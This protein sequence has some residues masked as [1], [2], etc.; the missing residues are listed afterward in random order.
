MV[1][2]IKTPKS[3]LR[4]LNY[5]ENKVK[6]G[7]ARLIHA[8]NF[9]QEK[10]DMNFYDKLDRFQHLNALNQRTTNKT[11]HI[12]L[13][14]HP[15]ETFSPEKLASIADDYM[16]RI[17]F[18]KQPYLVYEHFDAGHPHIHIV[19]SCIQANGRRIPLHNIGR[20]KSEPARKAIESRYGLVRAEDQQ[21]QHQ[22]ILPVNAQKVIYGQVETKR[23]ITN[24]LDAVLKTYKYSSLPE[25]NAILRLYNVAADRGK[26]DSRVFQKGGLL[27]RVLD[28]QGNKVGVPIKASSIHSKPTLAYLENQFQKNQP[29]KEGH[30]GRLKTAI[31][32]ALAGKKQLSLPQLIAAL[33]KQ[34]IATVRRQS[35]AGQLYGI[36]FIDHRTRCVFNGS[37]LGKQ[38]SAVGLQKRCASPDQEGQRPS[39]AAQQ[40]QN[41]TPEKAASAKTGQ[42]PD[43]SLHKMDT[44]LIPDKSPAGVA[45]NLI[46]QLFQPEYNFQGPEQHKKK[47]RR[48]RPSV[49]D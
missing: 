42:A 6:E 31:D 5:N 35:A 9:L 19:T 41:T 26:E 2:K 13:N 14:F 24:V 36:T 44:A 33:E 27:Y 25:L 43:N 46:E 23:G 4:V 30:A 20:D 8:G 11:V 48:K 29:L 39:Q 15:T 28:A 3:I 32:W 12:S 17:G 16:Q 1:T 45:G 49:D 38:Y 34:G 18:G 37:D 21:R 47:R 7:N 10:E 22:D 40:R